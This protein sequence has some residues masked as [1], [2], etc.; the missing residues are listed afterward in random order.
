MANT[1]LISSITGDTVPVD[2]SFCNFKK[3]RQPEDSFVNSLLRQDD[4]F[5]CVNP[6][7]E[8]DEV[9][10]FRKYF[11]FLVSVSCTVGSL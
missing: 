4:K 7:F 2:L 3:S 1:V 11:N 6:G 5:G 8:W 10:P 9:Q